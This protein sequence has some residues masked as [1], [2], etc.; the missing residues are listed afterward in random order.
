M[1]I[2]VIRRNAD[3]RFTAVELDTRTGD[4]F[5]LITGVELHEAI[6]IIVERYSGYEL[7]QTVH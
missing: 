2:P 3:K 5:E 4:E 1:I 7:R 6:D